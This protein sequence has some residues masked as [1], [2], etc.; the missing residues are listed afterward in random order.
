MKRLLVMG[1]VAIVLAAVVA[2]LAP[3]P[4]LWVERVYSRRAYPAVAWGRRKLGRG[5]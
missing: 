5:S 1:R 4:P 2:A 3:L